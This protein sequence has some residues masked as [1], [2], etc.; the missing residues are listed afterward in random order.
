LSIG[1]RL[2][3]ARLALRLTTRDLAVKSGLD[4]QTIKRLESG[5]GSLTALAKL[6]D[7][8]GLQFSPSGQTVGELI[9]GRRHEL[10]LSLNALAIQSGLSKPTILALERS[11]GLVASLE[12]AIAAMSMQI[13]WVW[14]SRTMLFRGDCLEVLPTI[15]SGSV[16]LIF[17]DLPYGT[18]AYPWDQTIPLEPLWTEFERILTQTGVVIF[19][20]TYPFTSKLMVSNEKWFKFS[21]VWQR[22]RVTGHVH[23]K[24]MPLRVHEDILVFS[25]SIGVQKGPPIGVQ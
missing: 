6:T 11:S 8:L 12:A 20:A 22:S 1:E 2:T 13:E 25:L 23:A 15:A 17:C 9:R 5:S 3:S 19:T 10:G 16:D 24:Q 18:T 7:A 4:R 14:V 21:L